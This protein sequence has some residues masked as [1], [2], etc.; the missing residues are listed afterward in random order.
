M[1]NPA[2]TSFDHHPSIQLLMQQKLLSFQNTKLEKSRLMP[3]LNFGYNNMTL[4]GMG[5]DNQFYDRSTRFQ[6]GQI[7]I[8]IPIFFGPQKAKINASKSVEKISEL[9][10]I[11]GKQQFGID[12]KKALA[13]F[14]NFA[15]SVDYYEQAGLKNAE[16]ITNTTNKQFASGGI[17]YLEWVLLINQSISIQVEYLNTVNNLNESIIQLN[18][19]NTK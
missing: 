7:G 4:Q 16:L 8:G 14:E 9:N 13:Q 17:N 11:A 19:F 1:L 6:S 3:D 18:Y 15:K 2:D 12:Y 10:Y 5:A